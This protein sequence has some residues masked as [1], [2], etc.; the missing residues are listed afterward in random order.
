MKTK[1]TKT[2]LIFC[3]LT[4]QHLF[5]QSKGIRYQ[6]A[7][8]TNV[9]QPNIAGNNSS[10]FEIGNGDVVVYTPYLTLSGQPNDGYCAI[11]RFGPDLCYKGS[12]LT[13]YPANS[14]NLFS[15][16]ISK[17]DGSFATNTISKPYIIRN[18]NNR[19]QLLFEKEI[20]DENEYSATNA[21]FS[22]KMTAHPATNN[23]F[24]AYQEYSSDKNEYFTGYIGSPIINIVELSNTTGEILNTFKIELPFEKIN[25]ITP[26]PTVNAWTFGSSE[27]S[28][29]KYIAGNQPHKDRIW[30]VFK[31]KHQISFLVDAN[32][33]ITSNEASGLYSSSHSTYTAIASINLEQLTGSNDLQIFGLLPQS[34]F[35]KII[36]SKQGITSHPE[37]LLFSVENQKPVLYTYSYVGFIDVHPVTRYEFPFTTNSHFG[38][39]KRF[40]NTLFFSFDR[41]FG[42]FD[43]NNLQINLRQRNSGLPFIRDTGTINF[44]TRT[45]N[46]LYINYNTTTGSGA[47]TNF[48]IKESLSDFQNTCFSS[49]FS[50]ILATSQP[51]LT[52]YES[53]IIGAIT[54]QTGITLK[55]D[56]PSLLYANAVFY[57]NYN[58]IMTVYLQCNVGPC[59]PP[60][61][62]VGTT[63]SENS[64]L[65]LSPNPANNY[66]E[67]STDAMIDK[68]EVYSLLGQLVKTFE[69]QEQYSLVDIA[70]GTYIVKVSSSKG[71]TNKT[72][73]IE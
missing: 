18:Y 29:I 32:N 46:S 11:S 5:S 9:V 45:T 56:D 28:D 24:F 69:K 68:V 27:I 47:P 36:E 59:V 42:T 66:F 71:V 61:N 31:L 72:L 53:F 6:Y 39:I 17:N 52:N 16:A 26:M 43:E 67:L 50:N 10:T 37:M 15:N 62:R 14:S 2:L 70:K 60:Q 19:G 44:P 30:V 58:N 33:T 22:P 13:P 35:P 65:T 3:F 51:A 54:P 73:I 20:I 34:Q 57:Q 23:L 63:E 40:Q 4:S 41:Y 38:D 1:I 12:E 7:N 64:I 21:P 49:N 25:T 8:V 48:L 55:Q